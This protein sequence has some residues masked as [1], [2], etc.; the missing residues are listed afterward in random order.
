M[1]RALAAHSSRIGVEVANRTVAF[2]SWRMRS[3]I[4]RRFASYCSG[5]TWNWPVVFDFFVSWMPQLKWTTLGRCR[6]THS[7]RFFRTLLL[8]PPLAFGLKTI[9]LPA[10]S[11]STVAA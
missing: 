4:L 7:S 8:S 6:I 1:L 5:G 3:T 11:F 9:A 2:V 10:S